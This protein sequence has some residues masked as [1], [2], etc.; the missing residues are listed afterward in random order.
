MTLSAASH[1]AILAYS[2]LWGAGLVL[3]LVIMIFALLVPDIRRRAS[4]T[5]A[6][7]TIGLC[8]LQASLI[9]ASPCLVVF[10][11][12]AVLYR[13]HLLISR[14]FSD[15]TAQLTF[16]EIVMFNTLPVTGFTSILFT[17][18]M[19]G[20]SRQSAIERDVSGLYCHLGAPLP[21]RI[22]GGVSLAGVAAIYIILGLI[23]RNIRR[24][25]PSLNSKSI[26]QAQGVSVDIVIRMAILSSMSVI[27]IM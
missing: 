21:K 27:V 25:P 1:A 5:Q 17:I 4:D 24:K 23:F 14:V 15:K 7:P 12:L 22:A 10:A 8:L 3:M 26:L 2:L 11:V 19:I 13:S 16:R 18:L 20:L 6:L 9:Y